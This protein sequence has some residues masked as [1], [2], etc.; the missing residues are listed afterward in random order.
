MIKIAGAAFVTAPF[1]V[2]PRRA[3]LTLAG[4]R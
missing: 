3:A 1:S 4:S 2:V